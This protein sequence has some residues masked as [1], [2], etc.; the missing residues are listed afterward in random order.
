[1]LGLIFGLMANKAVEEMWDVIINDWF[2]EVN[3]GKRWEYE[4]DFG[5]CSNK[6]GR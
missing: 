6:A 4:S 2:E 1:M 5:N 3:V